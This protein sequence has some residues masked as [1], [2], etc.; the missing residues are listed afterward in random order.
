M[1][2]LHQRFGKQYSCHFQGG[3]G[4]DYTCRIPKL[5]ECYP[6]LSSTLVWKK[7]IFQIWL[8]CVFLYEKLQLLNNLVIF[9]INIYKNII[10]F[11]FQ[12]TRT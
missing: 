3:W 6:T 9:N 1:F 4:G 11:R 12:Y 8:R 10:Y 5:E 7:F 2:G